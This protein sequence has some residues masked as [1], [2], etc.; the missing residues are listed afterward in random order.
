MRSITRFYEIGYE[1][2]YEIGHVIDYVIGL[3]ALSLSQQPG[4]I[5]PNT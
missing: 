5:T 1:I 4:Q 3:R 2:P